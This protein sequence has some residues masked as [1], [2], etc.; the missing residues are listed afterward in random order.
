MQSNSNAIPPAQ[1][2]VEALW[3]K[4]YTTGFSFD[5]YKLQDYCHENGFIFH[6]ED[7]ISDNYTEEEQRQLFNWLEEHLSTKSNEEVVDFFKEY[8][9][10]SMG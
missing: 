9:N 6:P 3:H 8:L 10:A 1:E 4:L 7:A 5:Y 2:I